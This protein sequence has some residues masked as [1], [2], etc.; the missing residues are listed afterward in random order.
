MSEA[1]S[2]GE[3]AGRWDRGVASYANLFGIDPSEV[4]DTLAR[5]SGKRMA[6]EAILGAGS[7]V[8]DDDALSLR[9]RRIIVMAALTT[10]GAVERLGNH[11]QKAFEEGMTI[12][13]L[14]AI[15]HLLALYAGFPRAT[16]AMNAARRTLV[17]RGLLD[18]SER[19][20][21]P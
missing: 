7:G 3:L 14:D 16:I 1:P 4:F 17:D 2:P 5:R 11:V 20:D 8:W 21:V 9:E 13:E 19:P 6:R 10:Q 18:A 15:M 12:E